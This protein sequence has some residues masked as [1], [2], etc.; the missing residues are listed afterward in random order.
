[1]RGLGRLAGSTP[2]LAGTFSTN[3]LHVADVLR[4]WKAGFKYEGDADDLLNRGSQAWVGRTPCSGAGW[5]GV[6]CS[7]LRGTLRVTA[8]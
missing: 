1:M 8:L 4:G 5:W 7:A 3:P 2:T 6:S